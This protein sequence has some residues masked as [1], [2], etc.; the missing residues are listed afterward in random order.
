M[1]WYPIYRIPDGNL[2]AAFLTYH[3]LGHLV[4][5]STKFESHNLDTRIVSPVVGL[6]SYNAQVVMANSARCTN[7]AYLCHI[8]KAYCKS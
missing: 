6:Q 3:S 4:H 1:A 8:V 5:R 2:R 7:I